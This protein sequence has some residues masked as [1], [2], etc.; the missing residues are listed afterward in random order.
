MKQQKN[1]WNSWDFT[2]TATYQLSGR[3]HRG[4][5]GALSFGEFEQAVLSMASPVD[6]R[7]TLGVLTFFLCPSFFLCGCV[8][9]VVLFS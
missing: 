4:S 7:A 3:Y 9:C 5:D 2:E 8:C 1:I 6:K